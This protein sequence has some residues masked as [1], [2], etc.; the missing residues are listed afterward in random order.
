MMA[1]QQWENQW[2]ENVLLA[3]GIAAS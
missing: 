3:L 1:S 2:L